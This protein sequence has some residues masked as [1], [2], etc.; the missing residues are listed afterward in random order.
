MESHK[1]KLKL[2]CRLC[3]FAVSV[4]KRKPKEAAEFSE[5]SMCLGIN[6]RNDFDEIHPKSICEKCRKMLVNMKRATVKENREY[7]RDT[8][9]T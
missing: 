9:R 1:R 7:R 2:L 3:G 8:D 6:L 4:K 5:L